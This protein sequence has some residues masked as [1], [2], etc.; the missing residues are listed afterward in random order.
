M[1]SRFVSEI[2]LPSRAFLIR[3][4][5]RNINEKVKWRKEAVVLL[6]NPCFDFKLSPDLSFGVT[7]ERTAEAATPV[8]PLSCLSMLEPLSKIEEKKL[9][10][11]LNKKGSFIHHS[12]S[13]LLFDQFVVKRA[14]ET[15]YDK[16]LKF[17]TYL[18]AKHRY[19]ASNCIVLLLYP[20]EWKLNVLLL[21]L[22]L[23]TLTIWVEKH[24]YVS[25]DP[26]KTVYR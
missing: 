2:K 15:L 13:I 10:N 3:R 5:S 21:I 24:D 23:Q 4:L 26:G 7:L 17:N 22:Q 16:V 9:D 14:E 11:L 19:T 12:C 8:C 20:T 18:N 25:Q 1:K 6:G